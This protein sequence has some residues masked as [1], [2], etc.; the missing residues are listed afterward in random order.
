MLFQFS[1]RMSCLEAKLAIKHQTPSQHSSIFDKSG[2][3]STKAEI[4]QQ[5][6]I[7]IHPSIHQQQ[8]IKMNQK[9]VKMESCAL[10]G[11]D[12][13]LLGAPNIWYEDDFHMAIKVAPNETFATVASALEKMIQNKSDENSEKASNAAILEQKSNFTSKVTVLGFAFEGTDISITQ[14]TISS[15]L[16][17][18]DVF[19]VKVQYDIQIGDSSGEA[20]TA[21]PAQQQQPNHAMPS[22]P[23]ANTA[24]TPSS[25]AGAIKPGGICVIL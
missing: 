21:D 1:D 17:V 9:Q 2:K 12:E 14:Q 4:I 23:T 25:S 5:D 19:R 13:S 24:N 18:G 20:T 7:I 16:A 15:R 3:S 22:F 8:Y 6:K 10:K 11:F